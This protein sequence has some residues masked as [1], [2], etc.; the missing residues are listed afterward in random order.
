MKVSILVSDS[1]HP[2]VQ[3]LNNW[4]LTLDEKV[5]VQIVHRKSDLENGDILFLVSCSELVGQ[6][7]RHMYKHTLVLHASDLPNGRG[8]SPHIWEIL[9]G[10]NRLTLTLLEAKE[11]VDSGDIW[12]KVPIMVEKHELYDEINHKIFTAEVGLIDWAIKNQN[13]VIPQKQNQDQATYFKKRTPENSK[14]DPN[15]S[16]IEQFDLLRVAD[17]NR[18][19]AYFENQGHEYKIIIQKIK[20]GGL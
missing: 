16:I 12:H 13:T 8:W 1:K 20:N 7:T 10:S 3:Y 15:K 6:N 4:R 5:K 18:F 2:V 19:P 17:P 11:P 9:N 14:L